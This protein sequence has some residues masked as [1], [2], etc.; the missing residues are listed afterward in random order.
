MDAIKNKKE[1]SR[2]RFE[3]DLYLQKKKNI[4]FATSKFI[5]HI[6]AKQ[7]FARSKK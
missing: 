6:Y 3:K 2:I 4:T 5:R 1:P 7:M